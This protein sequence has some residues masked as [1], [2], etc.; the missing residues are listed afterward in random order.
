MTIS[1]LSI[2]TK[3]GQLSDTRTVGGGEVSILCFLSSQTQCKVYGGHGCCCYTAVHR[4]PTLVG[5][6]GQVSSSSV[7]VLHSLC[8]QLL[9][10]GRKNDS[11]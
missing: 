3:S 8:T 9:I 11:L 2:K 1:V 10:E 5:H 7:V 4:H 6:G